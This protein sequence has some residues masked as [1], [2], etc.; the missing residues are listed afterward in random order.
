MSSSECDP[1]QSRPSRVEPGITTHP[2]TLRDRPGRP[3]AA[4]Y[5]APW[6]RSERALTTMSLRPSPTWRQP[7]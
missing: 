5:D 1:S 6:A 4:G 3:A 7:P 2:P